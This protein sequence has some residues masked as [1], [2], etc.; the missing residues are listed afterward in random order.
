MNRKSETNEENK[1]GRMRARPGERESEKQRKRERQRDKSTGMQ[2]TLA[3]RIRISSQEVHLC[4]SGYTQ[5]LTRRC[6]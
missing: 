3:R 6:A 5:K 4:V 1:K 2:Y